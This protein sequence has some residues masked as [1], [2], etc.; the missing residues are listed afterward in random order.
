MI[1]TVTVKAILNDA[2]LWHGR[3]VEVIGWCLRAAELS[4][5]TDTLGELVTRV[6]V[7][8]AWRG[9]GEGVYLD[10]KDDM[11]PAFEAAAI[12]LDELWSEDLRHKWPGDPKL[13]KLRIR[14]LLYYRP[15]PTGEIIVGH[16]EPIRIEP[17]VISPLFEGI[18][19]WNNY[20][21]STEAR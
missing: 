5:L 14:G 7:L 12:H 1:D 3:Q 10:L 19:E 9:S 6:P 21:H 17:E 4:L 15:I 8:G 16:Y 11:V 2:S 20:W 13:A 18:V